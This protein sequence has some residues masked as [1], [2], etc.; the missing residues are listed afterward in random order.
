MLQKRDKNI[1]E[2]TTTLTNKEIE[3]IAEIYALL[4]SDPDKSLMK[5]WKLNSADASLSDVLDSIVVLLKAAIHDLESTISDYN[6]QK[7]IIWHLQERIH[8]LKGD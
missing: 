5:I 3:R 8:D 1:K 7:K 2:N 6:L 4:D